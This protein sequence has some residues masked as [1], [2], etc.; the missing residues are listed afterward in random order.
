MK[1]SAEKT[2]R[3]KAYRAISAAKENKAQSVTSFATG[4]KKA[5][6]SAIRDTGEEER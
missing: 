4:V 3:G 2:S 5:V 1:K 6:Q